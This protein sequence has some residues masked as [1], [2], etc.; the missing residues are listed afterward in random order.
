MGIFD[1]EEDAAALG[2]IDADLISSLMSQAAEPAGGM[3]STTAL[4]TTLMKS[5]FYQGVPSHSGAGQISEAILPV[6]LGLMA[7][8]QAEAQQKQAAAANTLKTLLTM[9]S[10]GIQ[11]EKLAGAKEARAMKSQD[12][13]AELEARQAFLS[14]GMP[15][16][17][18]THKIGGT[19][20]TQIDPRYQKQGLADA[21]K[22]GMSGLGQAMASKEYANVLKAFEASGVYPDPDTGEQRLYPPDQT[23]RT[24]TDKLMNASS[25]FKTIDHAIDVAA[26]NPN[27]FGLAGM[28][29]RTAQGA[30]GQARALGLTAADKQKIKPVTDLANSARAQIRSEVKA[31]GDLDAEF[32]YDR[33][34]NPELHE[35]ETLKNM[36]AYQV[37]RINDDNGRLSDF[38]V[39][40]ALNSIEGTTWFQGMFGSN[41]AFI[42]GLSAVKGA[43][44]ER[45]KAARDVLGERARAT[46]AARIMVGLP[47]MGAN[48]D[49]SGG[50]AGVES[51]TIEAPAAA[52]NK[53]GRFTVEVE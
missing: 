26:R 50:A 38:D 41:Q 46:N 31:R 27:A 11:E 36:I 16:T 42:A 23:F 40:N 51:P 1:E 39:Q 22:E 33:W 21:I 8:K 20:I 18:A 13:A 2:D 48:L 14:S 28:M 10:L 53:V 45:V 25:A 5:P 44:G 24:A 35:V 12:R 15:V 30:R 47:P 19:T 43:M 6:V 32:T 4:A 9:K 49:F 29:A 37:A 52:P 7:G 34:F 3:D 17:K